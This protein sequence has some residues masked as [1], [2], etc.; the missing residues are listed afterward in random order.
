MKQLLAGLFLLICNLAVAA[1]NNIIVVLDTSGSMEDRMAIG[2]SR[3]EVVKDV[4]T[5]VLKD[6][7][8]NT[9]IGIVSFQGWVYEFGPVDKDRLSDAIRDTRP[10][11][12]TPLW[13]YIKIGADRLL[14]ARQKNNNVGV[15]KLI[16]AT[17]GEAQ[18]EY[19]ANRG[20]NDKGYLDD[21]IN[22]GIIID[23]IGVDMARDHKLS[24]Q[25]NGSYMRGDD[26]RS[27]KQ[28]VQR[29]VAEVKFEDIQFDVDFQAISELPE[30]FAA[31]A[32]TAV[33]T[34]QNHPVGEAAPE[35]PVEGQEQASNNAT[36]TPGNSEGGGLGFVCVASLVFLGIVVVIGIFFIAAANN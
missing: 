35:I 24:T 29:A 19:L 31:D 27:L 33:S 6:T 8:E 10:V 18:D 32:V 30:A 23:A 26:P 9:H 34:F 7:P 13:Q 5:N 17:D 20:H 22:R 21:I 11:G 36:L 28:A 3:M 1:D 15:Y 4:L 16:I 12:G 25:V 2:R 14:E